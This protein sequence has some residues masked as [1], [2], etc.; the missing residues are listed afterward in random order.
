MID[1]TPIAH[2]V[3]LPLPVCIS[4]PLWDLGITAS[5]SIPDDQYET[6]VRDVLM[7]LRLRLANTRIASPFIEFP[8]LLAFPPEPVPQLCSLHAIAYGDSSA[9]FSLIVLLSKEVSAAIQP[10]NN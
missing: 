3:G 8:A 2:S 1:V 10:P 5:Q 4:K 7:A 9:P 6:R